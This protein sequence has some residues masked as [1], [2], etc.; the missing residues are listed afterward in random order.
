M[1]REFIVAIE[2]EVGD[3]NFAYLRRRLSDSEA[4]K[5]IAFRTM[6]SVVSGHRCV[7]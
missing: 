7:P 1:H 4:Y 5:I 2:T 6:A 3:A